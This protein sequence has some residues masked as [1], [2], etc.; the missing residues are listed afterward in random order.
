[1]KLLEVGKGSAGL[2]SF[3]VPDGCVA[4]VALSASATDGSTT[5]LP[6]RV[7]LSADPLE[8]PVGI[9]TGFS[10]ALLAI[11]NSLFPAIPVS[12]EE[13]LYLVFQAKGSAV[14]YFDDGS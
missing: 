4:I 14:I 8:S 9:E 1:M 6:N 7:Y 13:R 11:N 10:K 2:V 5:G 3:D 12:P